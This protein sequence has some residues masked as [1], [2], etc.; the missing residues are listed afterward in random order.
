LKTHVTKG[1]AEN[2]R[3]GK[4]HLKQNKLIAEAS[5]KKKMKNLFSTLF[6]IV[7]FQFSF[8][9]DLS[10]I[11]INLYTKLVKTKNWRVTTRYKTGAFSNIYDSLY[12]FL[13]PQNLVIT[14]VSGD[15]WKEFLWKDDS[16][17]GT[18]IKLK[19]WNPKKGEKENEAPIYR[20]NLDKSKLNKNLIVFDMKGQNENSKTLI[21]TH[22]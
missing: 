1:G 9:Q 2:E 11:K 16:D 18:E 10:Q 7:L 14:R 20:F 21:L 19:I 4:Q 3:V 22:K 6:F 13:L 17:N 5:L 12:C 8:A 15:E